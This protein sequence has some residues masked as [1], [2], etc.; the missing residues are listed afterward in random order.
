AGDGAVDPL[1]A[2][3]VERLGELGD[4]R[5]LTARRPPVGDLNID[6]GRLGARGGRAARAGLAGRAGLGGL[7]RAG[8]GGLATLALAITALTTTRR[9]HDDDHDGRQRD[10]CSTVHSVPPR[11]LNVT[12]IDN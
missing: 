11:S 8:L 3:G 10:R 5:G 6:P 7:A 9:G 2:G 12:G 4:G 1:V